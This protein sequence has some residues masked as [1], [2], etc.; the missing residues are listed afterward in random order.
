MN[1]ALILILAFVSSAFA[2]L[3]INTPEDGVVWKNGVPARISWV[4]SPG[5]PLTG[6]VTVE[7]MEGKNQYNLGLAHTIAQDIPASTQKL[8]YTPP[9]GL[10]GSSYYA[11]RVRST[12]DGDYYSHYFTAG[13]PSKPGSPSYISY[14]SVSSAS[15]DTSTAARSSASLSATAKPSPSSLSA[16]SKTMSKTDS[17]AA[18]ATPAS[19]ATSGTS[20]KIAA[21]SGSADRFESMN[22]KALFSKNNGAAVDRCALTS[23]VLSGIAIVVVFL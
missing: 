13:D 21:V 15:L 14:W 4:S 1:T 8:M 7:L 23:G 18:T 17:S 12:A 10:P 5:A 2:S 19:S 9:N 6:N 11:I 3:F 16:S 22:A 20:T